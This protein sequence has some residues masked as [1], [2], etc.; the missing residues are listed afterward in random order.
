MRI[1]YNINGGAARSVTDLKNHLQKINPT[2]LLVMDNFN[3]ALEFKAMFPNCIVIHRDY[4]HHEGWEWKNRSVQDILNVWH[5][6]GHPEIVRYSTNEPTWDNGRPGHTLKDYLNTEVEL[7]RKAREQGYTVAVGNF[8]VG[9]FQYEDVASG[10]YD[11]YLR[12][13]HEYRHYGASHEYMTGV[14]PASLMQGYPDILFNRESVK[15][16]NWPSA[17]DSGKW[18]IRRYDW[19]LDRCDEI[20]VPRHKVI[21]TEFG[22]DTADPALISKF[23][24]W[25]TSNY[26]IPRGFA[27][28]QKYWN[29]LWPAWTYEQAI[30]EQLAWAERIYPS[31]YIGLQLFAWNSWWDSPQGFDYSREKGVQNH[32]EALAQELSYLPDVVLPKLP[33]IYDSKWQKITLKPSGNFDVRVRENP[34]TDSKELGMLKNGVA[35]QVEIHSLEY[36]NTYTWRPVKFIYKQELIVGWIAFDYVTPYQVEELPSTPDPQPVKPEIPMGGDVESLKNTLIIIANTLETLAS[37]I[38]SKLGD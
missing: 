18:W 5:S 24:P 19:F 30:V 25:K 37:D 17:P 1:S 36:K 35:T 32:I 16:T 8:S 23:Q 15:K 38:K 20:G 2:T 4:N 11:N 9:K 26:D 27:G 29:W 34:T 3:M 6:Q 10:A 14:L 12:S 28:L 7:M 13:I 31:D 22:W 21:L 33:D